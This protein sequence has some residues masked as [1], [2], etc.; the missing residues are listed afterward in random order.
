[1]QATAQNFGKRFFINQVLEFNR[2]S[3]FLARHLGVKI[4][5]LI[6][7]TVDRHTRHS[8]DTAPLYPAP[9]L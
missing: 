9:G 6:P 1:M 5:E 3:N 4:T 2:P 8:C 7:D